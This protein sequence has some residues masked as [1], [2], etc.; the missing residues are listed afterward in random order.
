MSKGNMLLGHARGKVG[1]LVFSRVN[2][3]QVTR[4]RA[5]VVKNPQTEAQMIQRILLNTVA[6]AYSKMSA[7]CDHSFEGVASGQPSMAYFMRR[8]LG[9]LRTTLAEIGDF[10]AAAPMTSPIGTNGLA[11]NTYVIS[12]GQLAEIIPTV[13]TGGISIALSANTYEAVLAATGL[14]RGDQLTII[15][16]SGQEYTDQKFNYS[17]II[18]DPVEADGSAADLS[19]AFLEN[20][21]I[22]KPNPR[23]E[24]TGHTYSFADGEFL[25]TVAA[26]VVN[27][28]AAIGSRQKTD[29]TWLRSNAALILAEGASIGYSMQESLDLFAAGGL[30]V[31]NPMYL[32]NA[33]RTARRAAASPSSSQ[34]FKLRSGTQVGTVEKTIV[35]IESSTNDGHPV[36]KLIDED[37][38][39]YFLQNFDE[40]ITAYGKYLTN[41]AGTYTGAMFELSNIGEGPTD[42]NTL[43]LEAYTNHST[44]ASIGIAQVNWLISK[45]CN[46]GGFY[47]Q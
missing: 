31:E 41:K 28:A 32:N 42:E 30:D 6:Q 47:V 4:A 18:L 25:T 15:T 3:K 19:T 39:K 35:A 23:N 21:A 16:V 2:G 22:V 26:Q 7:I 46:Y 24:N 43:C 36:V 10:D 12:K 34:V 5:A 8:N 13:A 38:N 37:G 45:G 33:V 20:G 1:D 17:R 11:S 9:L 27:M 29:G 40:D 14:Q 44:D